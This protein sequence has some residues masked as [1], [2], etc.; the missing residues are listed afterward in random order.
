MRTLLL[1]LALVAMLQAQDKPLEV[2]L[3]HAYITPDAVTYEA[4]RN[5]DFVKQFAVWEERTTH[6]KDMSYTGFYLYGRN[7][8]FEFLK[9]SDAGKGEGSQIALGVDVAGGLETLQKR[10]QAAGMKTE[11]LPITRD[12]NGKDVAWFKM[13]QRTDKE[14]PSVGIW[15]LEYEPTFLTEW[16]PRTDK[17]GGIRREDVLARYADVVK[18][19]PEE[20]MIADIKTIFIEVPANAVAQSMDECGVL[21]LTVG[22]FT[23]L[24]P[25]FSNVSCSSGNLRIHFHAKGE[26]APG[27][28]AI[29][30]ELG[31]PAKRGTY[32]LGKT[33]LIVNG[34]EATWI[35]DRAHPPAMVLNHDQK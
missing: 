9:P 14:G 32:D 1:L 24:R 18:Q 10:A 13:L 30:F 4:I 35:F 12:F 34:H 16:N 25:R 22:G 5:S 29:V 23:G 2:H 8:Y 17:K 19:K 27:I 33:R 26:G 31:K 11:I 21:G 20:K 6:R 7:T 3:N 15:T 28:Y